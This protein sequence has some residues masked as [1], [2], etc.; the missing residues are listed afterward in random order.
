MV[1]NLNIVHG[2]ILISLVLT[3]IFKFGFILGYCPVRVLQSPT[4]HQAK[5]NSRG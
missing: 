2:C 3:M 5:I 4:P 1:G